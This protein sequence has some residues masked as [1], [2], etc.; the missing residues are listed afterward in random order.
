LGES[1]VQDLVNADYPDWPAEVELGFRAG[2][3]QLELKLAIQQQDHKTKQQQCY[4]W[5]QEKIGD[6]IIGEESCKLA[7]SV[8]NLLKA[9][10]QTLCCAESCTGGL[11]ASMLT[12]IPGASAAFE[13]G[14]VSYSNECKQRL[15]NVDKSLLDQH[16]AVSEEVVLAMAEGALKASGADY[17]IA[18]SGIAGPE[19]GTNEKPVGTAY[20]A[21]GQSNKL[22][23]IK[24][25][26]PQP[27][28]VF[29]KMM[30]AVA[31]DMMRR[32]LL[33]INTSPSFITRYRH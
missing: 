26:Y 25:C 5:L 30:A 12:E 18:I 24:L 29:Q 8:L 27:R 19:G 14:I 23:T 21:W 17:T 31:L 20:L 7:E 6:S 9:K 4:T 1:F 32:E 10:Q 13:A 11:I 33:A 15:L 22:K 28:L 16:G 3:P 2:I